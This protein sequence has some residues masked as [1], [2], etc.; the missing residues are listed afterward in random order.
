[1]FGLSPLITALLVSLAAFLASSWWFGVHRRR[2]AETAAGIS[3]LAGMKWRECAGLVLQALG[4]KGFVE[5]PSSRQPGDG[6][7]EF[8]LMNGDERCLLGYKHGT[9]YRLGEANVR[10]FANAVQLQGASSGILVTLGTAE[11]FA[12]DLAR[13]Y[14]VELIDGRTLW[15]QVEPFASPT[16]VEGI[17]DKAA[18][19]I[20]R[21]QH[22]GIVGSLVLGAAVFAV[23]SLGQPSEI[24]A[25]PA[26]ST[27]TPPPAEAAPA[28]FQDPASVAAGKAMKA[29]EEVAKLTDEQ[30]AQRRRVAA[31]RVA[32]LPQAN[33]AIWSTASTLVIS[34][35]SGDGIDSGIVNDACAVLLEYEELRYSRL[36]LEPPAGSGVPVRWRQCQ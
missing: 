17:R 28:V 9:A 14:G 31:A 3:A 15:P 20:R 18:A 25:A 24:E 33:N 2:K 7:T 29:L 11:A 16:L 5:M 34:L 36:Q 27:A 21:G 13:R 1:M 4:E 30:R 6:G 32:D 8:L 35:A 26:A 12:R 19:E 23:A 10:D 22:M